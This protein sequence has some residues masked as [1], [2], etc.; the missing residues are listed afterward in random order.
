MLQAAQDPNGGGSMSIGKKVKTLTL[1]T[2]AALASEIVKKANHKE[3]TSPNQQSGSATEKLVDYTHGKFDLPAHKHLQPYEKNLLQ[4]KVLERCQKSTSDKPLVVF[5]GNTGSG[6]STIIKY[7]L[8]VKLTYKNGKIHDPNEDKNM[9]AQPGSILSPTIGHT[10][11]PETVGMHL[12]DHNTLGLTFADT[13][14]FFGKRKQIKLVEAIM[15]EYEPYFT[16][17]ANKLKGVVVVVDSAKLQNPRDEDIQHIAKTI[18]QYFGNEEIKTIKESVIMLITHVEGQDLDRIMDNINMNIQE[19]F[20]AHFKE[21]Q[22]RNNDTCVADTSTMKSF[23]DIFLAQPVEEENVGDLASYQLNNNVVFSCPFEKKK[24]Q[25]KQAP[26]VKKYGAA[27]VRSAKSNTP[28][29]EE[30]VLDEGF[31]DYL[32]DKLENLNLIVKQAVRYEPKSAPFIASALDGYADTVI[33]ILTE[34]KFLDI[35]NRKI[36]QANQKA[37]DIQSAQQTKEEAWS[38][39]EK[40]LKDERNQL[41]NDTTLVLLSGST[42][43]NRYNPASDK[44]KK[45]VEQPIIEPLANMVG[46]GVG[47]VGRLAGK[48]AAVGATV[49]VGLAGAGAVAAG[50][51]AVV[52][53]VQAVGAVVAGAGAVVEAGALAGAVAAIETGLAGSVAVAGGGLAGLE[54]GVLVGALAGVGAVVEAGAAAVT[55]AGVGAA[56]VGLGI[57]AGVGA[58]HVI[59]KE[60][61]K[62]PEPTLLSYDYNTGR[63]MRNDTKGPIGFVGRA[64]ECVGGLAGGLAGG[65]VGTVI[66]AGNYL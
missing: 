26:V 4:Q 36:S 28:P 45:R 56:G 16:L 39:Q 21:E 46:K 24:V 15:A 18:M 52:A 14:G 59:A 20:K 41:V 29:E 49:A 8:G 2:G 27:D 40:K 38:K 35:A 37:S 54:V 5:F 13:E 23:F 60:V 7:L 44:Y 12:Y 33:T 43:F 66:S 19:V 22:K 32:L 10:H 31:R 53:G 1:T 9:I 62:S 65:L 51:A 17:F 55:V 34:K 6:K 25:T 47:T 58:V 42:P 30:Y 3:S 57:G 61:E 11:K 64:G 50:G 63:L 48:T